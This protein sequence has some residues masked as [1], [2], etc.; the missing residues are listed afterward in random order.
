MKPPL[1]RP[2]CLLLAAAVLSGVAQTDAAV[3]DPDTDFNL[4]IAAYESSFYTT[5]GSTH[6]CGDPLEELVA[7]TM[8]FIKLENTFT[9]PIDQIEID[10]GNFT[11][12]FSPSTLMGGGVVQP[13][14]FSD[15]TDLLASVSPSGNGSL[16]DQD[17]IT[18]DFIGGLQP[19]ETAI[20]QVL[21]Q[22][23]D[24]LMGGF[25]DFRE[26]FFGAPDFA[27]FTVTSGTGTDHE[28][29]GIVFLTSPSGSGAFPPIAFARPAG[30][31]PPI[32]PF[33]VNQIIPEP[34]AVLM[35]ITGMAAGLGRRRRR[36]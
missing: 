9:E 24:P 7:H 28:S 29:E 22:H 17:T 21:L 16:V 34:S 19:G 5:S 10:L 27:T 8:P 23:D 25:V 6:L 3:I 4:D 32:Q 11:Y 26:A 36:C 20:F 15:V 35:V 1:L 31:M 30:V 2:P 12:H 14:A 18:V 13:G 33:E